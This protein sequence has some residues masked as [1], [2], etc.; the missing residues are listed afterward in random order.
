LFFLPRIYP[1]TDTLIS[2]LTHAEQ[3]ERLIA[4]GAG[5]IQIRE[6]HSSPRDFYDSALAASGITNAHQIPLIINDRVDIAMAVRAAGVHLG[7]GDVAPM[8][9]RR[10]M[11]DK[12]I[13]GYSTHTIDQVRAAMEMP[14]D[15]MAFGPI[16]PTLSKDVADPDVGLDQLKKVKQIVGDRGLVAIGGIDASNVRSVFTAGADS[17]AM[18]GAL[19]SDPLKITSRMLELNGITH[20]GTGWG[21]KHS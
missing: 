2:G 20:T 7:Q 19:I 16:F 9:A 8:D 13:I 3:V 10:I 5:I 17:A 6:K 12:A 18:I 1:I 14:I 4:G 21:V 11:G 15:Y